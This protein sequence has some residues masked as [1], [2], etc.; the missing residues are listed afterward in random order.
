MKGSFT[1]EAALDFGSIV[2]C[3][4][5][6]LY[7]GMYLHDKTILDGTASCTAQSGRLYVVENQ[8][9]GEG[10]IDWERFEQK[11]LL[12]RLYDD[13]DKTELEEYMMKLVENRLIVC[14][15]PEITVETGANQ[16]IVGYRAKT[17]LRGFHVSDVEISASHI[18]GMAD[19][20]GMEGEEFVRLIK[21]IVEER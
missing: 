16:T 9:P 15:D 12:W 10:M 8:I 13:V 11:S 4:V 19:V 2:C 1:V 6:V 5:V 7:M 3:Q 21:A 18:S 17:L 20:S 14:D